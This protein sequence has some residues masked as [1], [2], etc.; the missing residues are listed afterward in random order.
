M[1]PI[2]TLT[3]QSITRRSSFSETIEFVP[4]KRRGEKEKLLLLQLL[5]QTRTIADNKAVNK[6]SRKEA[7]E[8]IRSE[9]SKKIPVASSRKRVR[10]MNTTHGSPPNHEEYLRNIGQE[11]K[12]YTKTT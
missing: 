9:S 8:T 5:Q 7:V 1:N 3:I 2:L 4:A 12:P 10:Y 6:V 11:P